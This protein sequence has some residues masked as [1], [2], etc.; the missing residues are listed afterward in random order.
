VTEFRLPDATS[1]VSIC[2]QTGS[3]KTRF[4]VWLF[5]FSQFHKRPYVIIDFKHDEL[6]AQIPHIREITFATVPSQPGLYVLRPAPDQTEELSDW[7]WKVWRKGNIGLFFDEAYMVKNDRALNAI[8][9]QGRSRKIPCLILTQRPTYCSRFVFS[10]ANYFAIFHL[11]D[12]RDYAIIKGFTPQNQ[13]FD[14]SRPLPRYCARWYDVAQDYAAIIEP[15]ASDAELL[16]I[17]RGK[18]SVKA[19]GI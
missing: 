18:L 1:R 16:E 14:F 4:A 15:V 17:Y 3:G 10:E 6:I 5:S 19:R 8:L 11:N 7:L 9:T 12:K 2:G 13:V